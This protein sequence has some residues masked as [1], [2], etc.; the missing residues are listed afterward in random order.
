MC[1]LRFSHKRILDCQLP[2]CD[3][4]LSML[5]PDARKSKIKNRQSLYA[6]HRVEE[7]LALGVDS[8]AKFFA[9]EPKSFLEF[10]SALPR[11][12]GVDNDHHRELPLHNSLV[13]VDDAAVGLSQYLRNACDYTRVIQTKDGNY[14]PIR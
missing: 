6:V 9:C 11:A 14:H 13:Y 7:I 1:Y 8:Y 3:F 4:R 10:R 2:I 5:L 12:G